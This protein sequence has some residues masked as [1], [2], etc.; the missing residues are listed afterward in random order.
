MYTYDKVSMVLL[1]CWS[2]NFHRQ[3]LSPIA[4]HNPAAGGTVENAVRW[5][6]RGITPG[7]TATHLPENN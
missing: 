4:L 3:H 5:V 2:N 6:H 1:L 7:I